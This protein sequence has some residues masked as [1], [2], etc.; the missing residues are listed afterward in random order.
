M[1]R[2]RRWDRRRTEGGDEEGTGKRET[3]VR[4]EREWIARSEV[5][6]DGGLWLVRMTES[7]EEILMTLEKEGPTSARRDQ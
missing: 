3:E 1:K 6:M 5:D 2:Q 4:G 7:G